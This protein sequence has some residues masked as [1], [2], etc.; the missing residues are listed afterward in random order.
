[1]YPQLLGFDIRSKLLFDLYK[2]CET[3]THFM[4]FGWIEPLYWAI[5]IHKW[6]T[7]DGGPL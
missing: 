6:R 5:L 3:D 2:I 4:A 7:P 1:M